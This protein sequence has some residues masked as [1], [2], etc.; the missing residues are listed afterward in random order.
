MGAI[1]KRLFGVGNDHN[2]VAIKRFCETEWGRDWLYAYTTYKLEGK[3][4][5]YQK[6]R[7]L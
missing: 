6:G 1:I 3:L 2:D 7:T 4:P 5:T